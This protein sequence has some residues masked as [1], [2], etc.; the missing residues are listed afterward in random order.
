MYAII[1]N[2]TMLKVA[3]VVYLE[4]ISSR[5]FQKFLNV[6]ERGYVLWIECGGEM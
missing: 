5:L 3:S 4:Y 1:Y 2:K 6:N